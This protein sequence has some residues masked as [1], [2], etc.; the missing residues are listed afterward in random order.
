MYTNISRSIWYNK[1]FHF[2]QQTHP[3]SVSFKIVT[4]S[5]W[6][7]T[8]SIYKYLAI[9]GTLTVLILCTTVAGKINPLPNS[10]IYISKKKF[11][12]FQVIK[13]LI[14][15]WATRANHKAS[16]AKELVSLD[17][18]LIKQQRLTSA[19][20]MWDGLTMMENHALMNW[21][22][23]SLP[24]FLASLLGGWEQTGSTWLRVPGPTFAQESSSSSLW[25]VWAS[26]PL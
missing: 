23:N 16:A 4:P 7:L 9:L 15:P 11:Y 22:V 2:R 25:E 18:S 8:M 13:I 14:S 1:C 19:S 21:R 20:A 17:C 5:N 26:G 6:S 12:I 3:L 10:T 24:S